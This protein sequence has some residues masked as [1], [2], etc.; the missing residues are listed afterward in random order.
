[1]KK[2]VRKPEDP[3]KAGKVNPNMKRKQDLI[4]R[5]KNSRGKML[6]K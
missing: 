3:K 2:P 5:K 6:G 1:M 4:T